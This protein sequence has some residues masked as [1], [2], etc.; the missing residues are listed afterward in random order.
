MGRLG[1][2]HRGV[3]VEGAEGG[4]D[5]TAGSVCLGFAAA[6]VA[7][8]VVTTILIM[9]ELEKRR[10]KTNILLARLL[11]FRYLRQYR[12]AT[13]EESGRAGPLYYLWITSIQLAAVFV[14][15]AVLTSL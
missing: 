14:L 5:M 11:I 8:N 13:L 12:E 6:L 9:V 1:G 15:I 4:R 3:P 7:V 10:I 2:N